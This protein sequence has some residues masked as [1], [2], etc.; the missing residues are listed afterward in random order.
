MAERRR[1]G[2]SAIAAH[3]PFADDFASGLLARHG[4]D[5]LALARTTLLIPNHRAG[6]AISDAFVR[7]SGKGLLLPRMAVIGDIDLGE[8]LG[9]LFDA[10]GDGPAI[11]PAIEPMRRLFILADLVRQSSDK[12]PELPEAMRLA[13]DFA[14]V[15]DQLLIEELTADDLAEIDAGDLSVHWQQSLDLFL[16]VARQWQERL[17]EH[18]R[19]DA[20]DRRN[21]LLK[22]AAERWTHA[23]PSTPIIA[24]GITTAAP[25]IARLLRAVAFL[26][27]GE[28]VIPGLDLDQPDTVWE[29]LGSVTPQPK[30][31]PRQPGPPPAYSH[32]QFH[33][34]L[35]LNAMGIDRK[36]VTDWP[37]IQRKA[38][39]DNRP[40]L[41]RNVFLPAQLSDQWQG[42]D[43]ADSDTS[44]ISLI[45]AANPDEEAQAIALLVRQSL[46]KPRQRIAIITPDRSL[47][48]RIS[49]HLRRWDIVADDSAGRALAVTPQGSFLI[50]LARCLAE[51]FAP[52][53]LLAL[54]KHPLCADGD[55]R[56][57]WLDQARMLD[58]MLRGPRPAP[59]LEG[60]DAR[61]AATRGG[62]G[63]DFMAWWGALRALF[64]SAG[65]ERD[66]TLHDWATLLAGLGGTLSGMAAWR[67]QAGR[68]ASG[69]I[70]EIAAIEE[71]GAES[72]N[73]ARLPAVLQALMADIAIRP[74]FGS[75]PRVAIYGLLE[76]RLQSADT[77]ICAG[78]N[79]GSWPQIPS[80]DPWLAPMA[81]RVLGLPLAEM[82]IGLAGQDLAGALAARRVVL[83]R[84]ARDASAPAIASRFLLRIKAVAGERLRSDDG[85]LA[86]ARAVDGRLPAIRI[87]QPA[88]MP[89]RSQRNVPVSVTELDRLRADPFAFYA[90]KILQL[91]ALDS[92]DAEPSAAW[93]G[94]AVHKILEDW[95]NKDSQ[96]DDALLPRARRF[97]DDANVHPLIIALWRP[98]LI[99]AL[100]WIAAEVAGNEQAGRTVLKAECKGR[101]VLDGVTITGKADRIDRL[102]DGTLAIVDYKTGQPPSAAQVQQGFALQLGL[103]GMIAERGGFEDI[104]GI[105]GAFE[106]WSLA[107]SRRDGEAQFGYVA[108]PV[109][110]G[111]KRSGLPR[112]EMVPVATR[113]LSEALAD[114]ILGDSPFTAKLN[115]DQ[116]VYTDY[117]QLMRLDEW[118]GRQADGS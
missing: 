76:A 24:T 70:E 61:I 52:V 116:A 92:V 84:S 68:A 41:V 45:E 27:A 12:P 3:R 40:R 71:L 18:G 42:L 90:R 11:P 29:A 16:R 111:N 46:E 83:T 9:N 44:G 103:L 1:P 4:E 109:R 89:S 88:P 73:A 15:L 102:A 36:E 35:L 85:L 98:R 113:F 32:P 65:R 31:A 117:D 30:D 87:A 118:Y 23:S 107:K 80:P 63:D 56:L 82:R 77:V 10:M 60:I 66:R 67:G 21:R 91:P 94:T 8:S 25:A 72:I 57:A 34:K 55:G 19:I 51:N 20:A 104:A 105:A 99:A 14:D 114:W 50:A 93:R 101:A 5:R 54:L 69:L 59:G 110:E 81:R 47:A 33:L 7:Q 100:E 28:V 26:P 64:A 108:S 39:S 112:D 53:P 43:K 79:E 17:G 13:S 75:H 58:L 22:H 6:R 95:I 74:A 86:L 97:L 2:I 37:V 48:A 96:A 106:Y 115:P 78:L 38:A 49:A 62:A